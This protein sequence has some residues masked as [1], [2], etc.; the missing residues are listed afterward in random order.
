VAFGG[1]NSGDSE[2]GGDAGTAAWV[3]LASH[4]D[5]DSDGVV[6]V[7][8]FRSGLKQLGLA[9]V[10]HAPLAFEAPQHWTLEQWLTELSGC[11]SKQVAAECQQLKGWF[12]QYDGT[13][14]LPPL[15]ANT[16]NQLL[17]MVSS[18]YVV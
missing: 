4:F 5:Q 6:T 3:K 17:T 10:L 13:A 12:E 16:F 15:M 8:E 11:V 9:T 14:P 7:E 2:S 18:L 1:E